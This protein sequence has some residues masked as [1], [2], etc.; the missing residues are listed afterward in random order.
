MVGI[1]FKSKMISVQSELSIKLEEQTHN[2]ESW[3]R[4]LITLRLPNFAQCADVKSGL[5]EQSFVEYVIKIKGAIEQC[6]RREALVNRLV[7]A[8]NHEFT[9]ALTHFTISSDPRLR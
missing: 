9:D 8:D 5:S 7:K 1:T 2:C 6:K 4:D 3:V